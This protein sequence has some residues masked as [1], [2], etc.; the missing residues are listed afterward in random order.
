MYDGVHGALQKLKVPFLDI[1]ILKMRKKKNIISPKVILSLKKS[2]V[3]AKRDQKITQKILKF[4]PDLI[5]ITQAEG[6][7]YIFDNWQQI[8]PLRAIIAYWMCDLARRIF[9]NKELGSMLDY[10]FITNSGQIKKYQEK[11]GVKKIIYLPQGFKFRKPGY[12]LKPRKSDLVFIGRRY[13]DD[14][15]Y[16][17]RNNFLKKLGQKFNIT[18]RDNITPEMFN[19]YL[20]NFKIALGLNIE[21]PKRIKFF[22]SDRFFLTLGAGAFYLAEYF[23]GIGQ[24]AKNKKHLVWFKGFDDCCQKIKY[25]LGDDSARE[26]IAQAGYRLALKKHTYVHRLENLFDIIQ[27]KT[28]KFYGFIK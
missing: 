12:Q 27:G 13:P 18:E 15:R 1:N 26:K 25:Y 21:M 19:R 5:L 20:S 14:P 22:T 23:P 8:K 28:D 24:L 11:W 9:P 7:R 17:Y 16:E 4:K 10:I 3:Y 6:L 2:K